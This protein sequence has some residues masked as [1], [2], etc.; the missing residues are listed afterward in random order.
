MLIHISTVSHTGIGQGSRAILTLTRLR[1]AVYL[2]NS[3]RT[4]DTAKFG[5]GVH[6]TA[7]LNLSTEDTDPVC[8]IPSPALIPKALDF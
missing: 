4:L 1:L 6:A 2:L 5:R 7:E 3:R 8:R